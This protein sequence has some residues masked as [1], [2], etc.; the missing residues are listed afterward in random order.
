MP[1]FSQLCVTLKAK[2]SFGTSIEVC[3]NLFAVGLHLSIHIGTLLRDLPFKNPYTAVF[4]NHNP[5]KLIV[6]CKD[7]VSIVDVS[8]QSTQSFSGIPQGAYYQPNALALSDDDDF[9]VAGIYHSPNIVCGFDMVSLTRLWILNTIDEVG[10]VCMH[11]TH[12]LVTVYGN[13]TLVLDCK[14]GAHIS[15][16]PKAD[17]WI[18]GLGVIEGLCFFSFL[19][20]DLLQT[21]TPPCT[22]PCC[23]ISFTSKPSLCIYRWRCGTGLLSTVCSCDWLL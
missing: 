19:T 9:M 22:S 6:A 14:T 10:A 11:G 8:T 16:L 18:Y 3:T 17:G 20:S 21:S 13:P 5:N 7:E 1:L 4:F 23:N 15:S 12:V 2:S